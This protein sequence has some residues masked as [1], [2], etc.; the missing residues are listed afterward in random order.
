MSF[1]DLRQRQG[2]NTFPQVMVFRK[3]LRFKAF[4][5]V[6]EHQSCHQTNL[7]SRVLMF[8]AGCAVLS[9]IILDRAQPL[10]YQLFQFCFPPQ[11]QPHSN[12]CTCRTSSFKQTMAK[13]TESSWKWSDHSHISLQHNVFSDLDYLSGCDINGCMSCCPGRVELPSWHVDF[14]SYKFIFWQIPV[15]LCII[16][17]FWGG[18]QV[19]ETSGQ[20]QISFYL[21]NGQVLEIFNVMPCKRAPECKKNTENSKL[22]KSILIT[23]ITVCTA[24]LYHELY[25]FATCLA[26]CSPNHYDMT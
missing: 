19:S 15:L 10:D 23:C 11:P 9:W 26:I 13:N 16:Y 18:G 21:S 7:P 6:S 24:K 22:T 20:V 3:T 17:T 12:S 8:L 14:V 4:F 1:D 25:F 5:A 2:Q